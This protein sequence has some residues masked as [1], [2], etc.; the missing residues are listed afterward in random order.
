MSFETYTEQLTSSGMRAAVILYPGKEIAATSPAGF[1]LQP[2]EAQQLLDQFNNPRSVFDKGIHVGGVSYMAIHGD[3]TRLS[4]VTG[5][6]FNDRRMN[7]W[8]GSLSL[9]CC[10][11]LQRTACQFLY[12]YRSSAAAAA[13]AR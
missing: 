12:V 2:G 13:A 8:R 9:Q 6:E 5:S 11:Q 4:G 1:C 7:S 3:A 10:S